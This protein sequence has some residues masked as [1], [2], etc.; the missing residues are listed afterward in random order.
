MSSKPGHYLDL[1]DFFVDSIV[2]PRVFCGLPVS[3]GIPPTPRGY[4]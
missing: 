4:S 2:G 3:A 1:G